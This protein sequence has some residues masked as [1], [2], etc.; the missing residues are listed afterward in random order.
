MIKGQI[1]LYFPFIQTFTWTWGFS[2][3]GG[4]ELGLDN[5]NFVRPF[6]AN[7]ITG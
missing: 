4:R 1:P 7:T 5:F 3:T 6:H 2:G